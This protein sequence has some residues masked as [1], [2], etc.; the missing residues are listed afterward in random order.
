ME[1]RGVERE[2]FSFSQWTLQHRTAEHLHHVGDCMLG[3]VTMK[4]HCNECYRHSEHGACRGLEGNG[5]FNNGGGTW[6][7]V[8]KDLQTLSA[9]QAHFLI[10]TH[11][12]ERGAFGEQKET[13]PAWLFKRSPTRAVPVPDPSEWQHTQ[14]SLLLRYRHFY[15]LLWVWIKVL[16]KGWEIMSSGAQVGSCNSLNRKFLLQFFSTAIS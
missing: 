16:P 12:N 9:L 8:L 6:T 2:V 10:V 14:Y 4:E 5:R 15:S 3:E 13:L 1:T 7:G 11:N